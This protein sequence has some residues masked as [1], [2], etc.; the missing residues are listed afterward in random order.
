VSL[1]QKNKYV[2]VKKAI[3]KNLA[4]F[5]YNYLIMKKQVARTCF[6]YKYISPFEDMLGNWNDT[7]IPNTYSAYGDI[8]METLMLKCQPIMKKLQALNC[9]Q[10]IVMQEF[11]KKVMNL[12]DIKIDLVVKYLPQ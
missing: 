4:L 8:A 9:I 10:P 11:I 7:Q 12:K 5:L 3:D 2:V 6:D 1:F